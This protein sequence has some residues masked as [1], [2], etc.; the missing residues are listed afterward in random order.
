M[1]GSGLPF[2]LLPFLS[3]PD[4]QDTHLNY[5]CWCSLERNKEKAVIIPKYANDFN[6]IDQKF[7]TTIP[8]HI[9]ILDQCPYV[10]KVRMCLK[11]FSFHVLMCFFF[12]TTAEAVPSA[13]HEVQKPHNVHWSG[14]FWEWEGGLCWSR[15]VL[16]NTV[17]FIV[18]APSRIS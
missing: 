16:R 4:F 17:C 14:A 1:T 3:N 18:P 2:P 9:G 12:H 5:F 8:W 11:T 13:Y 6:E 15:S 10:C 7:S